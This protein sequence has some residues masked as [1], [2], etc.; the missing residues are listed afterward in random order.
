MTETLEAPIYEPEEGGAAHESHDNSSARGKSSAKIAKKKSTTEGS[1]SPRATAEIK[2]FPGR[3]DT[4]GKKAKKATKAAK[5]SRSTSA[6][7]GRQV[8]NMGLWSS[9]LVESDAEE[10]GKP[11]DDG[12]T[13]TA[14]AE[15]PFSELSTVQS[16]EDQEPKPSL[17]A[18]GSGRESVGRR[19][20]RWVRSNLLSSSLAVALVVAVVFL[21][22][23]QL[24]LN[25]DSSLNSARTSALTAAKSYAVD[26]ASYNYKSLDQNFGKVL[27]ES[28][29][30]F[31]QDFTQSTDALKTAFTRYRAS[32]S[33]TVVSAGLVS[34]TSTSAVVLVFLNQTVRNTLQKSKSTTESRVE[35]T[36]LRSDGR[37]LINQV[38]LL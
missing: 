27:N 3:A 24:S 32:A 36:L 10:I 20:L 11:S 29:P 15:G 16:T 8:T 33:G 30:T 22:L 28:T 37:W 2:V 7:E 9:V 14:T 21:A 38:S 35:I 26:L 31:K 23:S 19:T 1:K 17:T 34:A 12:P 5:A 6:S 25:S 4:A 13:A 18:D